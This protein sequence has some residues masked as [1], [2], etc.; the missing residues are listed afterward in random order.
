MI[1]RIY[2]FRNQAIMDEEP[3]NDPRSEATQKTFGMLFQHETTSVLIA[4]RELSYWVG[5]RA[6]ML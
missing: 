6:A 3:E 2:L 4:A 5:L 1:F